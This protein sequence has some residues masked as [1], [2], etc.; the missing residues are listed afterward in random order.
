MVNSIL[1]PTKILQIPELDALELAKI[2]R[3]VAPGMK[4]IAVVEDKFEFP[5]R[6]TLIN[7]L[8]KLTKI[9]VFNKV[10]PNPL[11]TDISEMTE[12]LRNSVDQADVVIG[13][14]GGSTL[15]SA[16][17]LSML[18]VNGGVLD[19]YLGTGAIRKIEKKGLPLILIP[20]TAGTGSEVT[21]VGV[22]TSS[23]GRKYTLGSEL[24][25]A[26]IALLSAKFS[27]GM[28]PAL[29]AS[30]GF[31][32]LS[33]ALEAI[34]N[35]NAI[36]V[37]TEAAIDAAACILE[38]IEQAYDDSC[39]KKINNGIP[40]QA[41]INMLK[42]ANAAGIAFSITGTA[43]VHAMSFILSEEW[44]VPHGT[45]CAFTLEDIYRINCADPIVAKRILPLAQRCC[46]KNASL[47]LLLEE[48]LRLKRK[49]CLPE[50]FK[51]LGI[52]VDSS[53]IQQLFKR[54]FEDPKMHNNL[55]SLKPEQVYELIKNKI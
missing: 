3:F 6:D 4:K 19:D 22:Y 26:D 20:T 11:S 55:P 37:T 49:M 32:A 23:T 14:G 28:P 12:D 34:W 5:L 41:Q 1:T 35:K 17:G 48:I 39:N 50:T 44:H 25:R 18:A 13:I 7:E 24:F 38:N 43:S 51:D 42:G 45:A 31:D 2:C 47:A 27:A 33:H 9:Q 36:E 8:G 15:D 52:K 30:T 53:Q 16:K 54:S 46:G 29:T 21:K 10:I 40:T